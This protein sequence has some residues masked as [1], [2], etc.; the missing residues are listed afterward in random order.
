MSRPIS[1]L[2]CIENR[3]LCIS[4]NNTVFSFGY[5]RLGSL[6]HE[7]QQVFPPKMISPLVNIKSISVGSHI[8]CLDNDGN[9]YT[10]GDNTMGDLG[11]DDKLFYTH[12]LQKVDILPCKEICC[13]LSFTICL[14]E[15]G[16]LYSF[17]YNREGQLRFE[18]NAISHNTPQK[19][20]LLKDVEIIECGVYHVFCKTLNNE[21]FCW[22][23]NKY[24]Q[25][26]LGNRER[27]EIPKY[28]NIMF[29]IIK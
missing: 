15:N 24:G 18:N 8:V 4:D 6:G 12:L 19:V 1:T 11:I 7:E 10:C 25:L 3:T 2:C 23:Y 5:S 16:D 9:V 20:P 14:C 27:L 26:G 17:G 28:T 22:G 13:G 21:I 29:I